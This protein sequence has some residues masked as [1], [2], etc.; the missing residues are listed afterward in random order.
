MTGTDVVDATG[1]SGGDPTPSGDSPR[2]PSGDGVDA[3]LL[4]KPSW[5]ARISTTLEVIRANPTGR[6]VLKV[7]VGLAGLLVVAVGA[8]LI[9]LPGPGW[10]I[11][12]GG[13][14]IW[15]IEFSWARRLLTFTRRYLRMWTHWVTRQSW[16][17]RIAIGLFGML[18]VGAVV[19]ISVWLSFG[20]NLVD[21]ALTRF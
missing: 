12:L 3:G 14:G 5:R 19:W 20:V 2:S 8:L 13:L 17:V 6:L 11:V 7:A 10:L 18:F 4:H 21:E 16:T 15:A 1:R 9:P